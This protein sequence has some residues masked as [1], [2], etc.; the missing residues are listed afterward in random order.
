MRIRHQTIPVLFA[1]HL[2]A[3]VAVVFVLHDGR[4]DWVAGDRAMRDSLPLLGCLWAWFVLTIIWAAFGPDGSTRGIL[5]ASVLGLLCGGLFIACLGNP[6]FWP[7]GVGIAITSGVF[8][9]W[10]PAAWILN[11]V[12]RL[13]P[14]ARGRMDNPAREFDSTQ[15]ARNRLRRGEVLLFGLTLIGLLWTLWM[16][17]PFGKGPR[18]P[19]HEIFLGSLIVFL[20]VPVVVGWI[21]M[22]VT[23]SGPAN[24]LFFRHPFTAY[25]GAIGLAVIAVA[26]LVLPGVFDVVYEDILKNE[27]SKSGNQIHLIICLFTQMAMIVF[28]LYVMRW[29]GFRLIA[30]DSKGASAEKHGAPA[31]DSLNAIVGEQGHSARINRAPLAALIAVVVVGPGFWM[32]GITERIR[33]YNKFE[34]RGGR[35]GFSRELRPTESSP[36]DSDLRVLSTFVALERLESLT[37]R[38]SPSDTGNGT[39]ANNSAMLTDDGLRYLGTLASVKHLD[40]YDQAAITDIGLGHLKDLTRLEVLNLG[41]SQV[42]DAGLVHLGAMPKLSSLDLSNTQITDVGLSRLSGYGQLRRLNLNDTQVTDAGLKHLAGV[43]KLEGLGVAGLPITDHGLAHLKEKTNL[44]WLDLSRTNVTDAGLMHL[45]SLANLESLTLRDTQIT[46]AGLVH[47]KPLRLLG[48]LHLDGTSISDRGLVHLSGI[49]GRMSCVLSMQRT[50]ITNLGFEILKDSHFF[51]LLGSPPPTKVMPA[52]YRA[53]LTLE[54]Y[55]AELTRND[56]GE[57]VGV[58]FQGGDGP[59]AD[60]WEQPVWSNWKIRDEGL[61]ALRPLAGLR[62]L[63]LGYCS[64][65]TNRCLASIQGL[66]RL[67][68]LSLVG[69]TTITDDGLEILKKLTNLRRLN[70]RR[71]KVTEAGVKDLEQALPNCEIRSPDHAT[72]RKIERWATDNIRTLVGHSGEL[73]SMNVSPDGKQIVTRGFPAITIWDAETGQKRLTWNPLPRPVRLDKPLVSTET[74]PLFDVCFTPAGTR[75]VSGKGETVIVWDAETGQELATLKGLSIDENCL[76]FS[77]DGKQVAG[78]CSDG[79]VRIWDIQTGHEKLHIDLTVG[80]FHPHPG[81]VGVRFSPDGSRIAA[82]RKKPSGLAVYD[83]IHDA[84]TGQRVVPLFDYSSVSFSPDGKKIVGSYPIGRNRN[85]ISIFDTETAE[86][87]WGSPMIFGAIPSRSELLCASFSPDGTR[88]VS[89]GSDGTVLVS[90]VASD[91]ETIRLQ[92]Y[93]KDGGPM[94][95]SDQ[96][97]RSAVVSVTF[98][99]DGNRVISAQEDGTIRIWDLNPPNTVK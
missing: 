28:P 14:L 42:T 88:V 30:P 44:F 83:W 16:I 54:L 8:V 50:Q 1:L 71:T 76:S 75:I 45:R 41:G 61:Q 99:P 64:G 77:P 26:G 33:V 49:R 57:V 15:S 72:R 32:T 5:T 51:L 55:G 40:L 68:S 78:G 36:T 91:S 48:E 90:D 24:W 63:N 2:L 34:A 52:N 17:L 66:T 82:L 87:T 37:L 69:I 86:L 43:P 74:L 6:W 9:S 20:G 31:N 25:M 19:F 60:S 10:G 46:D 7:G 89:G 27:T 12:A 38:R 96:G 3:V 85:M 73:A 21:A 18:D 67:E 23:F 4:D 80:D 53:V 65:L 70:L 92:K 29:S 22:A 47:L 62:T 97:G 13:L 79:T 56:Q 84:E 81:C 95:G 94:S 93:S 98:S 58:D 39:I 35:Y 11:R 59:E